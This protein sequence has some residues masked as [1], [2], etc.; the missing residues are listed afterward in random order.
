LTG[1][2]GSQL[3]WSRRR[4]RKSPP[5]SAAE[6]CVFHGFGVWV[7]GQ[8][9]QLQAIDYRVPRQ[10]AINGTRERSDSSA[11]GRNLCSERHGAARN[12]RIART[13]N[14]Q[15]C[16]QTND[17]VTATKLNRCVNGVT[18]PIRGELVRTHRQCT[19]DR[20]RCHI[21]CDAG[22]T[23]WNPVDIEVHDS[24]KRRGTRRIV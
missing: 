15:R 9:C 24:R 22:R 7:V 1:Q 10:N 6:K 21:G 19:R 12:R 4:L 16:G 2:K 3:R 23:G 17:D 20:Q 11:G 5:S 14:G 8:A 13:Q 18:C